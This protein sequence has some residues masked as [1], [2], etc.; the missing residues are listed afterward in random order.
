VK[1]TVFNPLASIASL[2][3]SMG[4]LLILLLLLIPSF[5]FA[6]VEVGDDVVVRGQKVMLGA[7]TKGLFLARGGEMVEFSV[8]DK[9][10][11][12][13]L[14]GGDG[15]A[16]REFTPKKEKLYKVKATSGGESGTGLLLS[17]KKGR[18]M[19]FIDVQGSLIKPPFSKLP[20][21]GSLEIVKKIS[22][23]FHVVYLYTEFPEIAISAWLKENKF[24]EA[25]LLDWRGGYIFDSI[26][27]KG[28][29]VKVVIGSA[30]VVQS[31]LEY[32]GKL[33]TFEAFDEAVE[34]EGW[35][36]IEKGLE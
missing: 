12:K 23:K 6:G 33:F 36:E 19:L 2:R 27:E 3:F 4:A 14:S 1:S 30:A 21:E 5:A 10:L 31:A 8:D 25:P 35:K 28:L 13:N 15:W 18:G 9:V 29:K 22:E 32:K 34:V 17:L 16:Y 11:G 7:K 24:P 20:R 26:V